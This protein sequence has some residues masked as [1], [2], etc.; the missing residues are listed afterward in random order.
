MFFEVRKQKFA[1][2]Q[3]FKKFLI[4]KYITSSVA[5]PLANVWQNE[6]EKKNENETCF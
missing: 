2:L 5:L 3:A 1:S 6:N 4:D